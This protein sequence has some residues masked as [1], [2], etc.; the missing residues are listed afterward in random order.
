MLFIQRVAH[1]NASILQ[2]GDPVDD[3][4]Q[5]SFL[6]KKVLEGIKCIG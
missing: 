5:T 6:L 4:G 3:S 1:F 2:A